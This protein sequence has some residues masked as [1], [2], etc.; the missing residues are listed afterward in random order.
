M[1]GAIWHE[2]L[3]DMFRTSHL[4]CGKESKFCNLGW[5]ISWLLTCAVAMQLMAMDLLT[6]ITIHGVAS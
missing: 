4:K 2:V 5:E 1:E 3:G 6:A